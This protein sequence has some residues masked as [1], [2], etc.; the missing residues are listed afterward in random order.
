MPTRNIIVD[1]II[2]TFRERGG[3]HYGENVTE[4]QHALQ[5][6]TFARQNNESPA[7]V[8]ACL[9]HDYG[10]LVH[11]L[12]E[13]IADQGIDAHHETLGANRLSKWFEAV[14]VEPVR[15]HVAA[16]RYLCWKEADYYAGLSEASQKS[17]LLQGGPMSDDE[18]HVFEQNPHYINAVRLR[19]YDDMGKLPDMQTPDFEDFRPEL[20][21]FVLQNISS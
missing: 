13:D 16:K 12:G 5:C 3:R 17:L 18:G 14:V 19:K 2:E 21:Q 4:S 20:E 9:L 1:Q 6:A 7:L 10:H 8:A 11:D 15:L